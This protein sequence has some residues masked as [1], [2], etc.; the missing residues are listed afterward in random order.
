MEGTEKITIWILSAD[1]QMQWPLKIEDTLRYGIWLDSKTLLMRD[2]FEWWRNS[3]TIFYIINPF[4]GEGQPLTDLPSLQIE[5]VGA[6][7]FIQAGKLYLIYQKGYDYHLF[8][9]TRKSDELVLEW[10]RDDPADFL[11]KRLTILDDGRV[12]IRIDRPYGF[13]LS[14]PQTTNELVASNNYTTT[15][16]PVIFPDSIL[17]ARGSTL[18]TKP[19]LGMFVYGQGDAGPLYYLNL[20]QGTMTGLC[21]SEEDGGL[22]SPDGTFSA[23]T[24]W[25]LPST[26]PVP[27]TLFIINLQTGHVTRLDDY[28]ALTWVRVDE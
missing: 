5:G 6:Q 4:T 22:L 16:R 3:E 17:P 26:Q 11:E 21:F 25:H 12:V 13:D 20:D 14:E 27:K 24:R 28:A 10:L 2:S 15:M 7:F 1:G 8:D 18:L 19:H 23:I 9:T